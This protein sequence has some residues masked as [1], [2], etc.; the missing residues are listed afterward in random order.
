M[1]PVI[2][3]PAPEPQPLQAAAPGTASLAPAAPEPQGD[4]AQ[5]LR[6]TPD[7]V[8]IDPA[9]AIGMFLPP[10]GNLLPPAPTAAPAVEGERPTLALTQGGA[11]TPVPDKLLR[12]DVPVT[13]L[14][15]VFFATDAVSAAPDM[16]SER[17]TLETLNG[18]L[19]YSRPLP[20][21]GAQ[22]QPGTVVLQVHGDTTSSA[23]P[24]QSRP[25]V[26]ALPQVEAAARPLPEPLPVTPSARI[27][28]G[29]ETQPPTLLQNP[30]SLTDIQSA[31]MTHY[32]PVAAAPAAAAATAAAPAAMTAI[33]V[34]VG[35]AAWRDA[36]GERVL[37]MAHNKVQSAEIRL[38]PAELGP[39]RVQVAIE[40]GVASIAFNAQHAGTREAIELALPKLREMFG[41][42]GLSLSD[43]SV[44][45][46]GVQRE[47]DGGEPTAVANL[48]SDDGD[49]VA[50]VA[51]TE[52]P[53]PRRGS[54]SIVDTF[55]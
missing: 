16:M 49:G 35:D 18:V 48:E 22:Q 47:T 15:S 40:D 42:S 51:E 8:E 39:L 36:I 3:L 23:P 5:A 52:A 27:A 54:S 1:L 19:G 43:A 25:L 41:D 11:A 20:L 33:D 4:F 6:L 29:G 21:P 53:A 10:I 28:E 2:T 9:A 55:A 37:W 17:G 7:S 34:P 44:S 50:D 30:V 32:R 46:H 45:E 13:P 31:V 26:P 12:S 14:P 38:S 24:E